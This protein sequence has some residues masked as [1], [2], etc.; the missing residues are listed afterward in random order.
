V[1]LVA[2][3]RQALKVD[4]PLRAVFAQ[5]SLAA[6]AT[7]VMALQVKQY[8]D[9]D[10]QRLAAEIDQLSEAEIRQLLAQEGDAG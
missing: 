1:Q 5:P 4:L 6:L 2:R 7:E 10:V 9:D 8:A 3:I